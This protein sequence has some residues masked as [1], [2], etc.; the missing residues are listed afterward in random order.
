MARASTEESIRGEGAERLGLPSGVLGTPAVGRLGH[1]P[2]SGDSDA[3][4]TIR[5]A[6]VLIGHLPSGIITKLFGRRARTRTRDPQQPVR[7][8]VPVERT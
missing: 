3:E 8:A 5:L 1:C 6:S 4:R 7:N 2:V